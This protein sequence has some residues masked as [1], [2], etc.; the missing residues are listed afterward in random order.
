MT[1]LQPAVSLI[2]EVAGCVNLRI[3]EANGRSH[4]DFSKLFRG[5]PFIIAMACTEHGEDHGTEHG[6]AE[7]DA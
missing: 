6:R 3:P 1:G 2:G 7:A 4:E 5:F